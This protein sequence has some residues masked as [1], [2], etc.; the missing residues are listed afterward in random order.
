MG[1]DVLEVTKYIEVNDQA[2]GCANQC[3]SQVLCRIDHMKTRSFWKSTDKWKHQ[4][5]LER[6]LHLPFLLAK[7]SLVDYEKTEFVALR[8]N[9]FHFLCISFVVIV[10]KVVNQSVC[11]SAMVQQLGHS[12]ILQFS[13]VSVSCKFI[14]QRKNFLISVS[15]IYILYFIKFNVVLELSQFL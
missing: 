13:L 9:Q 1:H 10:I 15:A 4:N 6:I 12:F 7:M 3:E 8:Y 2:E 5:S 11:S 14:N